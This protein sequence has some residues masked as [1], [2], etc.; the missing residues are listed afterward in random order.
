MDPEHL[1]LKFP[2]LN[3]DDL[4]IGAFGAE[5]EGWLDPYSL[6]MAFKKKAQSLG[7]SYVKDE[8]VN[9]HVTGDMIR[10]IV[11]K[12]GST[13]SG[14]QFVNAMGPRAASLMRMLGTDDV[15]VRPRKRN[16]F[17]VKCSNQSSIGTCPLV[18][19]PSGVYF[20]SETSGNYLCG[21]SPLETEDPDVD[22]DAERDFM[23][24]HSHFEEK[25]WP[26][27]AARVPAFEAVKVVHAWVGHYDYNTVDQNAILG[28]HPHFR[29]L[30]LAN[31]FSGHGLQQSPAVGRAISELILD[32]E[33]KS[34]DLSRFSLQRFA[35]N[36]PIVE[37]N[38]I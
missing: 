22:S 15:P 3:A 20:R 9:A 12:S 32:G 5:G 13:L 11:L 37:L 28:Q 2:W 10:Q 27:L 29:N 38:V 6:L 19:D 33:Y 21:I 34:I 8:V 36:R 4:K 23:V 24:D 16:V 35:Q 30:F 7:V 31:G 1:R 26:L 18:I 14:S 25:I 17:V